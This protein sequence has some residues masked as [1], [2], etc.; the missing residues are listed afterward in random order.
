[1]FKVCGISVE[2]IQE[3][4]CISTALYT[5]GS[6]FFGCVVHKQSYTSFY[7]LVLN[8]FLRVPFH[9]LKEVVLAL[10]PIYT[11]LITNKTNLNKG[12]VI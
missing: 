2:P 5:N 4:V 9:R 6:L 7:T 11:G 8:R 10:S 1:M 12:I 3:S